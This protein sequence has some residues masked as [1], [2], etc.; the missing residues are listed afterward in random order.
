MTEIN[1]GS[2][3]QVKGVVSPAVETNT[4]VVPARPLKEA[5]FVKGA[6]ETG[7]EGGKLVRV[8]VLTPEPNSGG[9]GAAAKPTQEKVLTTAVSGTGISATRR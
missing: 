1:E 2:G 9:G 5:P 8:N 3:S 7:G 6:N 4:T